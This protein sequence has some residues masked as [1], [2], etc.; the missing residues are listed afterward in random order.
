[1]APLIQSDSQAATEANF[2]ELRH[3]K[4]F[5]RTANKYGKKRARKQMIAIAL[6]NKRKA[7]A[8]KRA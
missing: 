3:G 6:K 4:T 8:R 7:A 2:D 1:M 5:R